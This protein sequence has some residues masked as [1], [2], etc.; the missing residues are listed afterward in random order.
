MLKR[1]RSKALRRVLLAAVVIAGVAVAWYA[2]NRAVSPL[3]AVR[4]REE[5]IAVERALP[6]AAQLRIACYNIAHGRGL[7]TSNWRMGSTESVLARLRQ[8]AALLREQDLD[9]VVLN[10]VDFDSLWSGHVNQAEFIAREAGFPFRAE[11]RNID[12]SL[13]FASLRFGNAILS[14]YPVRDARRVDYPSCKTWETILAGRKDGLLCTVAVSDAL[15]LRVLAVHF[16]HRPEWVRVASAK[17]VDDLC[18]TSPL[19]F[20]AA[21]DFNSTRIGFP[22]ATL[23]PEGRTAISWLLET[24]GYQTLP[25]EAPQPSDLTFPSVD[26]RSVIDWI[27]VPPSW[28]IRSRTV[29]DSNLSDH[30]LVVMEVSVPKD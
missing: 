15:Q 5:R 11:Q 7:A 27:L 25:T 16:D 20:L 21:G 23:D 12:M 1:I 28:T 3:T 8:I 22:R 26:A 13:P 10:E 4:V 18:K 24:G 9:I 29:I 14:R 17:V 19:P 30:K 2:V 6:P